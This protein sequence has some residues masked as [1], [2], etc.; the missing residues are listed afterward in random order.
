MVQVGARPAAC[1]SIS[2]G[3]T[4]ERA[5]SGSVATISNFSSKAGFPRAGFPWAGF[6]VWVLGANSFRWMPPRRALTGSVAAP[7][8]PST[9]PTA[10][11]PLLPLRSLTVIRG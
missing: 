2:I 3:P 5:T 6:T 10:P 8:P 9:A 11:Q 4:S 7:I 1:S